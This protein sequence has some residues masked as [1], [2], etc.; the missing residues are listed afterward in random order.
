MIIYLVPIL[1]CSP[2]LLFLFFDIRGNLEF[3]LKEKSRR[4]YSLISLGII[5][6]LCVPI[7]AFF[8]WGS[9]LGLFILH[10]T[11]FEAIAR[12]IRKLWKRIPKKAENVLRSGIVPAVCTVL[13]LAVGM[14]NM[15]NI[16]QTSYTIK[17]DKDIPDSG[18]RVA[19]L[20]DIHYGLSLDGEGI[21]EVA[22]RVSEQKPDI[23]ILCGDIIDEGVT[24]EMMQEVFSVLGSIESKEGVYFVYGNHDRS[25]Y[26][27]SRNYTEAE[28]VSA[29][30]GSGIT[31]LQDE[32]IEPTEGFVLIGREDRGSE[33]KSISELTGGIDNSD[34]ILVADHQPVEFSEKA[35][36][37]V[38]LQISGHTH[39]GQ[40]FPLAYFNTA[41]SAN[42]LCYGIEE[43]NG[44]TAIVSS[45]VAGWGFS[46]RTQGVSEYVIIDIVR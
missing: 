38:D 18:V 32:V 33:R 24:R 26:S 20:S 4:F 16:V 46:I 43:Y 13:I 8:G 11:V 34:F 10:F 17:T 7:S 45:G 21:S 25:R 28:L 6:L 44:M 30:G 2:I 40:I 31:I 23:V 12:L 37:G 15:T 41:I 29:I 19:L 27:N 1:L 39:G 42:D 3:F 36:S 9:T 5:A 35:E 14:W 22:R